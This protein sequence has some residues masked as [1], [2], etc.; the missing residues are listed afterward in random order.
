[1]SQRSVPAHALPWVVVGIVLVALSLRGPIIAP[2]PVITQLQSDLGLSAAT[3]GLL[4]GLGLAILAPRG[5][6]FGLRRKA[7]GIAD[8]RA[9]RT[10]PD[11][12]AR[13]LGLPTPPEVDLDDAASSLAWAVACLRRPPAF[14]GVLALVELSRSVRRADASWASRLFGDEIAGL[15]SLGHTPRQYLQMG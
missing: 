3:A 15:R 11:I 14:P 5:F 8:D 12:A 10:A 2:T 4:T 6:R 13:R 9:F 1:M 7:V